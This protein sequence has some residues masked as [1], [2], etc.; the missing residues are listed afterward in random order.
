MKKIGF[1]GVGVMGA[2]MVQNLMKAGYELTVYS[3]TKAKCEAVL[4]AGAAW[5]ETPAA[6]AAGQDA[7]LTMVGYPQD[8][9]QVYFGENG[10]F[11][12]VEKGMLLIDLTIRFLSSGA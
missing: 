10:I 1:I 2:P 6:C 5:A 8:V 12:R 11:E 4:Q 9:Q 7:V 3:R